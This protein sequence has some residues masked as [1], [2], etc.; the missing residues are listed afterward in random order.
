LVISCRV[1]DPDPYTRS[2]ASEAMGP[3]Y[4]GETLSQSE[5]DEVAIAKLLLPVSTSQGKVK[6]QNENKKVTGS[7]T[8]KRRQE[9][10]R[11]EA[12]RRQEE[13]G[14]KEKRREEKRREEKRREEKRREEKRRGTLQS[15]PQ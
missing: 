2:I 8:W 3:E 5:Q 1:K 6:P 13:K 12:G 15:F 9:G 4:T 14:R 10:G 7:R 11:K